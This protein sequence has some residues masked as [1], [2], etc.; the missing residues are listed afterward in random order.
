[1]SAAIS[2]ALILAPTRSSSQRCCCNETTE[3]TNGESLFLLPAMD[4]PL[5]PH[6]YDNV[7]PVRDTFSPP[8]P[9]GSHGAIQQIDYAAGCSDGCAG[10]DCGAQRA[11]E[12][13][14]HHRFKRCN[15]G[16]KRGVAPRWRCER[17]AARRMAQLR[18]W[19]KRNTLQHAEA[20]R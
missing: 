10:A 6:Q 17:S 2:M 9:G 7:S 5:V 14:V 8:N 12:P 15:S 3:L 11:A 16:D 19:A 13:R 1:M 20:D 4:C 18:P